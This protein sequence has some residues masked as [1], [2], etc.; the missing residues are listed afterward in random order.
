MLINL[1]LIL[2]PLSP[3]ERAGV[4]LEQIFQKAFQLKSQNSKRKSQ[5]ECDLKINR[6]FEF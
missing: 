6:P 3:L 5:N 4:R 2:Y 1:I